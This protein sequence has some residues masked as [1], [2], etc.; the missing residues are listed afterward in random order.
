MD[1][2]RY[3]M[4]ARCLK[5]EPPGPGRTAAGR[6]IPGDPMGQY[7]IGAYSVLHQGIRTVQMDLKSERGRARLLQGAMQLIG[8]GEIDLPGPRHANLVEHLQTRTDQ[9]LAK[10]DRLQH[11][12]SEAL[13]E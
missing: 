6:A 11:R 1:W 3:I 12:Q 9:P 13:V 10:M 4:G 8:I 7:D 2:I 5:V